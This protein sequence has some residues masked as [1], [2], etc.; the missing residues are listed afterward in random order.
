[1]A[2]SQAGGQGRAHRQQ[3][4]VGPGTG[5]KWTGTQGDSI[6]QYITVQYIDT[7]TRIDRDSDTDGTQTQTQIDTGRHQ[8]DRV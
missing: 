5:Q 6:A 1:M 7:Q 2:C 3:E 8:E 4:N